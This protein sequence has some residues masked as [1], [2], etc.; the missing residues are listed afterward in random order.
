MKQVLITQKGEPREALRVVETEIPEPTAGQVRVQVLASGIGFAD[1]MMRRG[2]YID[3]PKMPFTPGYDI[4]GIVDKHGSGTSEFRLGQRVAALTVYNGNAQ[5][6]CLDEKSLVPVPQG[7][8]PAEVTS[9]VLNYTSAY[10]MLHRIARV[11]P[12][13]KILIHG[14][15]GGVGTAFLQ[16]GKVAGLHM[17]G[18]ASRAKHP[19]IEQ[20]GATPIDYREEDFVKRILTL[21]GDGVD[22]VFDPIG[23]AHLRQSFKTLRKG[24]RLVAYGLSSV[25]T[26]GGNLAV[27]FIGQSIEMWWWSL[28]PNSK[29]ASFYD[30]GKGGIMTQHPEWIQEDL[31]TLLTLLAEGKIKPVIA[32]RLSLGQVAYAHEQLETSQVEGKIVLLPNEHL[33]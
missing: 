5:Y 9:I 30:I 32:E 31:A 3:T 22:A 2:L 16:L 26:H 28:L 17:Y 19:L 13:A 23:G 24:G 20:L 10:Q 7:L 15:A 29:K 6:I 14:A 18:T 11:K 33:M 25:V 21:T 4:C 27:T 12:G 8:D 1:V